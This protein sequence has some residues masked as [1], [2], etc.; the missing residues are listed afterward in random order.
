MADPL[1]PEDPQRVGPY[2]LAGRLGD[3]GQGTVYLGRD[4]NGREVAVKL[5]HARLGR[6][7]EARRRF[8]R[9]LEVASR[10]GGF[11]TARVLDADIQG[12][13]P[14]I[15]SEFVRGPSLTDLVRAQGPLDPG[16]LLRL[17]IG[18]ATA[19]SA[20]HRAGIVHRDFKPPNILIGRDGPRVI[21]FGIARALDSSAITVTSQ[22]VGTPAYMAPEQVAGD[23]VGPPADVFA[24]GGTIL[25]AATGR[26]PFPGDSIPALLNAVL[27]A[28]ADVSALPGPLAELVGACLAKDAARRPTSADVLFRLLSMAGADLPP[29][30]RP[31]DLL[32]RGMATVTAVLT[33]VAYGPP[34]PQLAPPRSRRRLLIGAGALAAVL[35]I[36]VPAGIVQLYSGPSEHGA[37]GT[38]GTSGGTAGTGSSGGTVRIGVM[39]PMRS[40]QTGALGQGAWAGAQQ[41]VN[42]FNAK[43][44]PVRVQLVRLDT[45]AGGEAQQAAA[46]RE[47]GRQKVDAVVGMVGDGAAGAMP[48]LEAQRIPALSSAASASAQSGTS[49]TYWHTVVPDMDESVSDLAQLMSRRRLPTRTRVVVLDDTAQPVAHEL[50]NVFKTRAEALDALVSV[51][52]IRPTPSPS[53]YAAVIRKLKEAE[54]DAVFYGGFPAVSGPLLKQARAAGFRARFYLGL[55]SLDPQ[56]ISG[57]GKAAEGTVLTCTCSSYAPAG[58]GMPA[59]FTGFATR[60]ARA[61]Q[62]SRPALNAPETYDATWAV[63]HAFEHGG[64]TGAQVNDYL[65]NID[66]PGVAQRLRFTAQGRLTDGV[67]Y[68]YEVKGGRFICLGDSATA[69]VP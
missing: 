53:N 31:D 37:T 38:T 56:L 30:A 52:V 20:I 45:I 57:A 3:G 11:C 61:N 36:A 1:L 12:D 28:E 67:G 16:A 55:P 51:V 22:V 29:G 8:V 32:E 58:A 43:K 62:G 49:W 40:P 41:A 26:P 24:W 27:N 10:V 42:E 63:L 59:A 66:V 6:V 21:D 35:A 69:P 54:A 15:V 47:A 46:A 23:A 39:A 68:A 60:Y 17:A 65:R 44:P 7:P 19:L 13:R 2:E 14:Y 48:V 9:E 18:T 50:A 33:K 4:P 34:P 5:L 25:F 64:R